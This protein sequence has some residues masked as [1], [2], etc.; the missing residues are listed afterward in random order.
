MDV[1]RLGQT[2]HVDP[3][4]AAE[5]ELDFDLEQDID[6][7]EDEKSEADSVRGKKNKKVHRKAKKANQKQNSNLTT[8][9]KLMNEE[10][11]AQ[12]M[13][14]KVADKTQKKRMDQLHKKIET[15]F[16]KQL[17]QSLNE[18]F[19]YKAA[20]LIQDKVTLYKDKEIE[21]A[22]V[23]EN[24][25]L[26]QD[27]E[28]TFD[29]QRRHMKEANKKDI[30]KTQERQTVRDTAMKQLDKHS[31]VKEYV[32][33]FSSNLIKQDKQKKEK[34][35]QLK[36]QMLEKGVSTK[37]VVQIEKAAHQLVRKDL[38]K[39]LKQNFL[40]VALS[41]KGE[42]T[43]ELLDN[44]S[45]Y[46]SM[47]DIAKEA[48]FFDANPDGLKEVRNE[49]KQ[50][51][52]QFLTTELDRQLV[53]TK[54]KSD[55]VQDLIKMFDSFNEV[56]KFSSF[57]SS[58]F[59]KHLN[60]KIDDQG[61]AKFISPEI[62]GPIESERD[63]QFNQN[64]QGR[65]QPE[66]QFDEAE[67]EDAKLMNLYIQSNMGHKFFDWLKIKLAIRK[68]EGRI[69]HAINLEDVRKKAS[70]VAIMRLRLEL[71]QLFEIRATLPA[72]KGPEYDAF[73]KRLKEVLKSLK[74]LGITVS[75][76]ELRELRDQSNRSLFFILKEEYIKLEVF[77]ES[78]PK[79]SALRL[80][81]KEFIAI[82][83][84]LKSE[85]K[86]NDSIKP[87][88]MQDLHF[89]SDVNIIEAA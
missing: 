17:K 1:S 31:T 6:L 77:L 80:K 60:K 83:E 24:Q 37:E 18:K 34:S 70:A 50:D 75:A 84:R 43:S 59:I 82:L 14:R 51:I 15:E 48:K 52:R 25:L 57:D 45:K 86:I 81:K 64:Q 55:S 36:Q 87:K 33:A 32:L 38:K 46:Y 65:R 69:K 35:R 71:R 20:D 67:D 88:L 42:M 7:D 79:N 58:Q 78:Q 19:Q 40:N 56:A 63:S 5:M 47:L 10:L 8:A 41:F 49:T 73:R 61:L 4:G 54:L 72:L 16:N 27:E 11:D 23:N 21:G 30:Q 22:E 53:E 39:M 76:K 26:T 28:S 85:T 62:L 66:P 89:L 44:Y 3:I 12:S 2:P 13:Y 9:G 74:R 29:K 68:E